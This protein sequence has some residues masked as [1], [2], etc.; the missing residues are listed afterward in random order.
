MR[1]ITW[2][3]AITI[4]MTMIVTACGQKDAGSVVQD[5]DHVVN[6]LDSYKGTG[7]MVVHTGQE[8][9]EYDVEVWYQK[10]HYYRIMLKNATK[11]VTQIVLRNDDGVFVLTP[12][13]NKSFRFQSNW[14]ENQGQVYLFQSLA[15]SILSDKNRQFAQDNGIY[16][17]DVLANYQNALLA[18]QKIWLDPKSYAP[19]RVEV[20]DENGKTLI[21][22]SFDQFEFGNKFEKDSFDMQ[23]NM[24]SWHIQSLP[25]LVDMLQGGSPDGGEA[26]PT[27]T[28]GAEEQ[29]QSDT[30]PVME[31]SYMP[32]GV[33]LQDMRDIDLGGLAAVM[34]RYSGTY[35]YTLVQHQP[36]E[37]T[38]M[39]WQGDPVQIGPILGVVTGEKVKVLSWT[40]RGIEFQLTSGDLPL[41][42]MV[43][44]AA[45]VQDEMGK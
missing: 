38:V 9:Q 12:Q 35:N 34:M 7:K 20:T 8:P 17:F 11:D 2:M 36:T 22:V 39:T 16:V 33:I 4:C 43:N 27:P 15:R 10:P 19:K 41:E 25:T 29:P 24:T 28:G 3:F 31:P 32:T 23:R 40:D 21:G 6:S 5:L 1:R 45:S 26:V 13:M 30:L 44:I 42:E 18:R 37:K 14:P